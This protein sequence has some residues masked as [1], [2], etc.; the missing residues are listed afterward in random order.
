[1][2]EFED[3]EE[4]PTCLQETVKMQFKP[5]KSITSPAKM[6]VADFNNVASN[7]R[8]AQ[9]FQSPFNGGK[10]I[11]EYEENFTEGRGGD[12]LFSPPQMHTRM[13]RVQKQ[14]QYFKSTYYNNSQREE[15]EGNSDGSKSV[16]NSGPPL[17]RE[18]ISIAAQRPQKKR[19]IQIKVRTYQNEPE[20]VKL[21]DSPTERGPE[22]VSFSEDNIQTANL[23]T[24]QIRITNK[25]FK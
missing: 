17:P 6:N 13:P 1:M 20:F 25:K 11:T 18:I 15:S 10:T 16:S 12:R 2:E 3:I 9:Q 4:K 14:S 22:D 21:D 7:L 23:N 24:H 5:I 8:T 19:E